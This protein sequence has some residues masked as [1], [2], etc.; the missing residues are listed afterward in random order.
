MN[1]GELLIGG[2]FFGGPCDQGISKAQVNSPYDGRLVGTVAEAGW[3]E[4]DAAL[5]A[6][7]DAFP[8][9]SKSPRHERQRLLR[10]I[11][12]MVRDRADELT[13]L[14]ADEVGKPVSA[15]RAEVTRLA[16][17]F[18]QA[19]DL[20]SEPSGQ[21]LPVDYDERGAPYICRVE[22]FPIG[23]AF[24]IV[25]W[26]WPFNL[27]A[28]KIAPALA[29][30]CPIT[31]KPSRASALST[32]A[33]G[34]LIHEAGCPAGVVN[35]VNCPGEMAT[36]A[37]L[38]DRVKAVSFTGSEEVGWGL[39]EK[40][41]TKKISLELGGDASA[42]VCADADLDFALDRLV[43]GA[44]TYAGQICIS[45][46]HA[47]VEESIYDDFKA[48]LIEKCEA[49]KWGDP[50]EEDVVVG[51]LIDDGAA[52]RVMEWIEEAE[53]KGATVLCG[54]NR[55]GR[56]IDATVVENV[57]DDSRLG[58]DEIFGPVMTLRSF[59]SFDEAVKRVNT[60]RF[61]LQ[62]G[63]FT[64]NIETAERAYQELE[65]GGVV[66]GDFPTLRFD[67]MP[68]GGVK[69]SGFGRE[70]LRYAIEEYTE[71]KVMVTKVQ[72]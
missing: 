10:K 61:G 41:T 9:W 64:R 13:L 39:K 65:V 12:A 71:L 62:A 58:C 54:G 6:A 70:G 36:K 30:G 29:A 55:S 18:E 45:I 4:V 19:A 48:R 43:A 46:Q 23:P 40:V 2:H 47:L 15:G 7:K 38:D 60:S 3:D 24:G 72:S 8:T 28:H 69:R 68:Y 31:I 16:L 11:G 50:R 20:L 56:I 53:G 14:L 37:A 67:T 34:R 42:I 5:E 57:P 66:I 1:H 17:T 63:V 27:G 59:S 22:R 51:P 26:N 33:L 52:D 49:V 32:L 44:F 21:L 25:P 35:M